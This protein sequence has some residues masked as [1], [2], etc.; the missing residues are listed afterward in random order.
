[1]LDKLK[2]KIE[3]IKPLLKR[4]QQSILARI[5]LRRL[6]DILLSYFGL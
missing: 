6:L 3:S 4:A 1:M 5:F 2:R